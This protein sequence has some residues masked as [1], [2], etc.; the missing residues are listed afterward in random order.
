MKGGEKMAV[1]AQNGP[2]LR[3]ISHNIEDKGREFTNA[4]EQLY[5]SL[6]RSL[7]TPEQTNKIWYGP[8]AAGCLREAYK[9]KPTLEQMKRDVYLLAE[10]INNQAVTWGQQQSR[11]Y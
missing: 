9:A 10:I 8:R 11:K 3:E 1:I 5:A 4:F 2:K 6:D 7:G